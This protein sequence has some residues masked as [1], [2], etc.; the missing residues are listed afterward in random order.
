MEN[1][2]R[3]TIKELG[4]VVEIRRILRGGGLGLIARSA[5]ASHGRDMIS[6]PSILLVHLNKYIVRTV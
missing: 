2:W 3:L 1:I 5:A 6:S 4:V